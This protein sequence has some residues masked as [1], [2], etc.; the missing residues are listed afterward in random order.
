MPASIE[1]AGDPRLPESR[2]LGGCPS[3]NTR[4]RHI[5]SGT[6]R[7][8][9]MPDCA[10]RSWACLSSS[11]GRRWP[12]GAAAQA[13]RAGGA[14]DTE[15][16]RWT[17]GR[18]RTGLRSSCTCYER[19]D[20]GQGHDLRRHRH[21]NSRARPAGSRRTSSLAST[22]SRLP[23]QQPVLRGHDRALRQP[24]RQGASSRS[25]ARSTRWPSNN[26]PELPARRAEGVRQGGLE[27][28]GRL[29]G[30][31]A[32]P[33][34]S[35]YLSPDGEEGYPGNLSVERHLHRDGRQRA[36][37]STTRRR[38][39]RPRRSTSPTTAI[40]TSPARTRARSWTTS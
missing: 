2:P 15:S 28:R 22:T 25:T 10:A 7:G 37:G 18:H 24:D 20:D 3:E 11:S 8:G 33:S 12:L 34:S 36:A 17:S 29:R 35:R 16:Q 39:T 21:R 5:P 31:T 23:G 32:R 9:S 40:S 38:P 26:G 27:G 6:T 30:R 19:P 1:S 4:P 13:K 14:R